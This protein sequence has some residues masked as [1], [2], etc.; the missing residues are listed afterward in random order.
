MISINSLYVRYYL[1]HSIK[2]DIQFFCI[3]FMRLIFFIY[4]LFFFFFEKFNLAQAFF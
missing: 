4:Y 2:K 1:G 3:Q